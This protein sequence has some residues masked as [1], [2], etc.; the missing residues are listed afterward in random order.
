MKFN[1]YD[2]AVTCPH[3]GRRG[4]FRMRT[5]IDPAA[6]PDAA[7]GVLD[8]G[9]FTYV[10]PHCG[11]KQILTHT[12]LFHSGSDRI[13][14]ALADS[15]EDFEQLAA[16]MRGINQR[17]ALDDALNRMIRECD[18]RLVRDLSALQEKLLLHVLHLDDRVIEVCKILTETILKTEGKITA[19]KQIRFNTDGSE[20]V[21]LID[22]GTETTL[23]SVLPK[24]MYADV[25][26]MLEGRM[27]EGSFLVDRE[28]AERVYR[29]LIT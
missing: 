27:P 21:L 28:W 20:W 16:W 18:C 7:A 19:A 24:E 13:L 12:C 2:T 11:E 1:E 10:C 22:D 8:A 6:D 17:D 4:T 26:R 5:L 25:G 14:Y 15:E 9:W 23:S 29:Q 3:C